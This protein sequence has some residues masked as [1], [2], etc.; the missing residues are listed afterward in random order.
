MI[1]NTLD[2]YNLISCHPCQY[3]KLVSEW[4]GVHI[5]ETIYLWYILEELLHTV[6][7]RKEKSNDSISLPQHHIVQ[8]IMVLQSANL[9][10]MNGGVYYD[11]NPFVSMAIIC[12]CTRGLIG[13]ICA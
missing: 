3:G 11:K 13:P 9:L 7:S 5:L 2:H 8:C 6:H 12:F 10:R 4:V 1:T